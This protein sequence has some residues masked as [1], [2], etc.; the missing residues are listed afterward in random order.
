MNQLINQEPSITSHLLMIK[1]KYFGFNEET[2]TNNAFQINDKELSLSQ[3]SALALEEFEHFV[4]ILKEAR[5]DI[6]V[7]EDKETPVI[8]DSVFPNNWFSTHAD[9]TVVTYPMFS[10]QRRL[11][12]REDIFDYLAKRFI[13]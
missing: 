7:I 2:A 4:D 12:R 9:G 8:P 11:E 1:P 5:L 10:K 6:T 13:I 3:I